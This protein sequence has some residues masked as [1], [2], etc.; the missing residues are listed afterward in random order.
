MGQVAIVNGGKKIVHYAIEFFW[1]IQ[2]QPVSS[3][4]YLFVR[5]VGYKVVYAKRSFVN[6]CDD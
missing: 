6:R 3:P 1:F 2:L 4:C 5:E